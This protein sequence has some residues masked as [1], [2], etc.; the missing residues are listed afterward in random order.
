MF[1]L[2]LVAVMAAVIAMLPSC[3]TARKA[4]EV[5]GQK[6]LPPSET[7]VRRSPDMDFDALA[8][9]YGEWKNVKVPVKLELES[10]KRFSISGRASMVRGEAVLISLRMLGFEVAVIY[11][12]RDSVYIAEKYHKILYAESL[13]KFTAAFGLTIE[14]VQNLLLGRVFVPGHGAVDS[15][16]RKD[17]RFMEVENT[18]ARYVWE[19]LPK[20]HPGSVDWAFTVNTA[21][22]ASFPVV[23]RLRIVP[24]GRG[25]ISCRFTGV[26]S[27]PV[28]AVASSAKVSATVRN[29]DIRATLVW[30]LKNARWNESGFSVSYTPPDNYTRVTTE[31]LYKMLGSFSF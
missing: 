14:D 29:R 30:T 4:A 23:Q 21:A 20:K 6:E 15:G 9:S 31:Q 7:E 17:F 3:H 18:P 19:M 5:P 26:V 10:P 1:R 24:Q 16:D 8:A 22:G 11:A 25:E 2:C 12:D 27:T 13:S 28:G